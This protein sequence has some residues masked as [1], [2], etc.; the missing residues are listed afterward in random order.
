MAIERELPPVQDKELI[1]NLRKVR[2]TGAVRFIVNPYGIVL[3]KRPIGSWNDQI[4]E[5]VF[6]GHVNFERWFEKED[7]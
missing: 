5:P 2:D 6:I 7:V 1:T 4:W 3:T